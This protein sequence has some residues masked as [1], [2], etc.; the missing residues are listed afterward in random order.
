MVKAHI[1]YSWKSRKRVEV[2]AQGKPE[3]TPELFSIGNNSMTPAATKK[4]F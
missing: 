2:S 4:G 3:A 1:E